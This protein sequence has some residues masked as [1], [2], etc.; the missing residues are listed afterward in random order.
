[1]GLGNRLA[2]ARRD[3]Q[4]AA[5]T[6]LGLALAIGLVTA[7]SLT[8]N[9]G[10]STVTQI[11]AVSGVYALGAGIGFGAAVLLTALIAPNAP[12]GWKVTLTAMLAIAGALVVTTALLVL[13][14]RV[15]Y[16]QWHGPPLSRVWLWQQFFTA[17]SATAQYGVMG[18]RY[19]GIAA[20]VLVIAASWWA[21]RP[22]H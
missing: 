11:V 10:W 6:M 2:T 9:F 14:H 13:E 16:S 15:Y 22:A 21:Y 18:V 7:A 8:W 12:P 4:R 3:G 20:P 1:M 19:Y 5:G 17:L